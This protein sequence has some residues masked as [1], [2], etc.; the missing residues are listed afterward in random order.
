MQEIVDRP[1]LPR[2]SHPKFSIGQGFAVNAFPGS[3][4]RMTQIFALERD[5]ALSR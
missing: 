4:P 3:A 1:G 5:L 2:G